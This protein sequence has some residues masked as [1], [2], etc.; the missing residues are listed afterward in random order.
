MPINNLYHTWFGRITILRTKQRLTQIRNFTWLIVGIQ[1]SRSVNLSK[2]AGKIPG[3]AKLVSL[4]RRLS[5]FLDN[6][7]IHVRSWYEPIAREW[8]SAQAEQ[9]LQIKLIVDGTKV[10]FAHQLLLVG[11][12]YRKRAIPIAWTWV[13]YVKGHSPVRQQLALLAY[14]RSLL[15][16][17][18]AVLLVGDREFGA[19][20][21]LRQLD[22][23]G[24][25]Y[26]LRVKGSTHVCLAKETEWK[27]FN[28]LIQKPGQ[29]LWLGPGSLT[30][31]EIYPVNL[32]LHW[33]A[34]EKEPWC[35]ATNLPDRSM[36]LHDYARRM[37]I[38]EMFG[39]MKNHGFDLESTR[40]RHSQRLSRLTLAVAL[41]YVWLIS[42]GTQTIR[43]GLRP[44]VDRNER[45]DLS[46]FQIGLRFIER[47]LAN[48][49]SFVIP[50]C[51]Y[52]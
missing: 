46:I 3:T 20:E 30:E 4:T 43:S 42:T 31:K 28:S 37:W 45:R 24:W 41:L 44:L 50:L 33:K 18:I 9:S 35:L 17:G 22:R 10:G 27:D 52:R 26:V 29:S 51:S 6:P 38:E 15:P 5:R 11:L 7:A 40:L 25:D 39:D 36:A 1:L 14:V 47:R 32:L 23:W 8:L 2:I 13:A 34:G 19:V 48:D 21:V 16:K 49:L 12:T